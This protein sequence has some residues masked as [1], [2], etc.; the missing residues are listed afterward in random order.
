MFDKEITFSESARRE[1]SLV[2]NAIKEIMDIT[3]RGL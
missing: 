3:L 2:D 1:L